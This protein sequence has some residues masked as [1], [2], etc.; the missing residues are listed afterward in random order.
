MIQKCTQTLA[1]AEAGLEIQMVM[2]IIFKLKLKKLKMELFYDPEIALL[3]IYLKKTKTLF[4]KNICTPVL[5]ALLFIIAKIWK[6][7]KCPSVDE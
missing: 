1:W 3:G 6:Q 2:N 5:I 4:Q 7:P